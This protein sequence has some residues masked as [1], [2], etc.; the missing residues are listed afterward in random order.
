[1]EPKQKVRAVDLLCLASCATMPFFRSKIG[2]HNFGPRHFIGG[3]IAGVLMYGFGTYFEG[4][5]PVYFGVYVF[6]YVI[7]GMWHIAYRRNAESRGEFIS[8]NYS[9][10]AFW[11]KKTLNRR[12]QK[13]ENPTY[14]LVSACS[15]ST[16]RTQLSVCCSFWRRSRRV[17]AGGTSRNT[18]AASFGIRL[19]ISCG[20]K[21]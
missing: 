4:P 3:L 13:S 1:M 12:L 2:E 16:T 11:F 8:P 10:R 15:F 19:E 14:S 18:A 5:P 21:H 7:L 17:T 6:A 20:R 9:G